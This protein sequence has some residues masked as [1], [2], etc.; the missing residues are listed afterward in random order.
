MAGMSIDRWGMLWERQEQQQQDLGLDPSGMSET[1][2]E[3]VA[4]DLALGLF[5]EAS[6][7]NRDATRYKR[8]I[9]AAPI[10][11]SNILESGVDVIKYAV[12]L[13]QLHGVSAE[14]AFGAFLE[15]SKVVQHRADGAALTLQRET[16]LIISDLDNCIADLS[17]F[18]ERV[19]VAQGGRPMTD[20]VVAELE[21]L[22]EDFYRNGGF[23]DIPAIAGAREALEKLRAAGFRIAIVTARPHH[24]Y[25]RVYADTLAW[26]KDHGIAHDLLLFNKDK[27]EAIYEHIFPARPKWFVEDRSK[28]ALELVGIGVP[29]VLMDKLWNRDLP[30][31]PLITRVDGWD[32][33]LEVITEG[34]IP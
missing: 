14:E 7:F 1:D 9:L 18:Q 11:R 29:V 10:E 4:K 15:K 5:E 34:E 21:R 30:D 31:H 20:E 19:S 25:K 13:L 6:E 26:L 32:E 17:T 28:H 22:K 27:A 8:H 24:Q 2:K 3:R 12:A 33:V 23:R 16:R